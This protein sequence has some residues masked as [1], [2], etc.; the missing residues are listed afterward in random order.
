MKKLLFIALMVSSISVFSKSAKNL[1][2]IYSGSGDSLKVILSIKHDDKYISDKLRATLNAMTGTTIVAYCDN[3]AVFMLFVD[4]TS[5]RDTNDLMVELKKEFS[6]TEDL[7]SFKD[8]DFNDFMKY[9]TPSNNDD[10][11]NLK[12][13]TTN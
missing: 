4:K 1:F 7:I 5:Y 10:A 2:K 8:G 12:K 6:K 11:A 9:C 3:H 13:L